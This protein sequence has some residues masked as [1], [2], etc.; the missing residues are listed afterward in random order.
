METTS[1]FFRLFGP[2]AA[3]GGTLR[4]LRQGQVMPLEKSAPGKRV[5]CLGGTLWVT[6][7]GDPEDHI[8]S[9]GEVFTVSRAG[10][11]VV[12]GLTPALYRVE[13]RDEARREASCA[14]RTGE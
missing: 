5:R 14:E 2:V 4:R 9:V 13:R 12:E 1:S 10:R 11:V 3:S 6:Q 7:E 8:L